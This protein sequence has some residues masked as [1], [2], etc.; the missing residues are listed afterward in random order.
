MDRRKFIRNIGVGTTGVLATNGIS[1]YAADD[2]VTITIL[3]TNDLHSHIEP[4]SGSSPEYN[5]KGG[6]ARISGMIK[7][8]KSTNQNTLVLDAGDAFQG[9][10]YFNYFGGELIYKMMSAV[11]YEASTIG[12]HEFDNQLSGL[13]DALPFADFPL[14]NSNYDFS[15]TILAGK[16]PRYKIFKKGGIKIGVY[17]LGVKLEGLVAATHYGNTIYNDPFSTAK[18]MESFLKQDEKCDLVL[19]L[20]HL[21]HNYRDGRIGDYDIAAETTYTDLFMSGHTHF[22]IEEPV[23][24]KNKLGKPVALNIA[25]WGGLVLGQVDFIMNRNKKNK[26]HILINNSLA[27]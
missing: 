24:V 6:L 21:G 9:T 8:I 18:E 23:V 3:H 17:G 25:W 4:F 10:P 26:E 2:L 20:S 27:S 11:G 22:Y 16:I 19:C 5:G 12:N 14:I 13:H 7:H 1:A 15:E